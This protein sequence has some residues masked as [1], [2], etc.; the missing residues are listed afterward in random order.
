[1]V[2]SRVGLQGEMQC[3]LC[4]LQICGP[5]FCWV[6]KL[7]SLTDRCKCMCIM[8]IHVCVCA[9]NCCTQIFCVRCGSFTHSG[10]VESS[11]ES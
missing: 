2:G 10:L 9:K 6:F 8:N 5:T 11:G 1:M 3:V 4:V 7:L